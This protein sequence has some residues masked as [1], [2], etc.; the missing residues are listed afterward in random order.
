MT[1]YLAR[2]ALVALVASSLP[3]VAIALDAEWPRHRLAYPYAERDPSLPRPS[4]RSSYHPITGDLRSYRPVDPLPWDEINRR[5]S[6]PPK[7]PAN[8]KKSE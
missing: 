8:P 2:P 4:M 5:V 3:T 7:P 6:P 1:R